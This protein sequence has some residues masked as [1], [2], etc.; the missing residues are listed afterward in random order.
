M[1]VRIVK[2]TFEEN[3]VE[4]F[5]S[6]FEEVYPVISKFEGCRELKLLQ[7]TDTKNV[8]MTYSVWENEEYL[9]H[10]RF[11][12]FFKDTWT[13]TKKLFSAKAEAW[14]LEAIK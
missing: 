11:S 8:L 7:V 13:K 9:D 6:L 5:L 2:M 1:I 14:S 12:S 10:Y 3:K 4:E